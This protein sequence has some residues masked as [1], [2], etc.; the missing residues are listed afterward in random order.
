MHLFSLYFI[1]RADG[2]GG[3]ILPREIIVTADVLRA[4]SLVLSFMPWQKESTK[5]S[6]IDKFGAEKADIRLCYT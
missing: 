1:S 6:G 5:K 2:V 4:L 3:F